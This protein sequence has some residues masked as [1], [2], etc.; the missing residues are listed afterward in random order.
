MSGK[1]KLP[2]AGDRESWAQKG[3]IDQRIIFNAAFI[4]FNSEWEENLEKWEMIAGY[5]SHSYLSQPAPQV[6]DEFYFS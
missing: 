2:G 4:P 5:F 1:T 6:V 3:L